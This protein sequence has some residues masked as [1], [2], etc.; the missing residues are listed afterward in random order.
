MSR[1]PTADQAALVALA[2]QVLAG[3]TSNESL[4]ETELTAGRVDDA[5]WRELAG[6]GLVGVAVPEAL[7]GTGLGVEELCLLA[8][9]QG[10]RLAPVPLVETS[11][12]AR[13]LA[14]HGTARQRERWLPAAC[15]GA[16][17]LALSTS[18]SSSA[19]LRRDG[20]TVSG[21]AGPVPQAAGAD[22]VLLDVGGDLVLV[23]AG[24]LHR[25]PVELTDHS[26]AADLVLDAAPAEPLGAGAAVRARQLYRIALCAQLLGVAEEGV[27]EAAAYLSGREQFGRPLATFQAVT[28]Q[29]GD[30]YCDVQAVRAVLWQAV[31][32]LE[33]ESAASARS[34]AT[35]V[36]W[37]TE[38][39]QRVQHVVQHLHGGIGADTTYPVHRRLLWTMRASAVLG[40]PG[41]ALSELAEHLPE[42]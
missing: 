14:E 29:L 34:V 13:V 15:D 25:E 8:Q 40:G 10:R 39:G 2:E 17:V 7:G 16:A 20:A 11:V 35:A 28:Q 27:R 22:A 24:H 36:W 12:A 41:A 32:A 37:A 30:A 9:A 21:R 1:L 23:E 42:T 19:S 6:A 5:L 3:R 31:W 26:L 4:A 38:A 18:A 33:H